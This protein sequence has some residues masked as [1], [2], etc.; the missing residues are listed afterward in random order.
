[1]SDDENG[2]ITIYRIAREAR[3]SPAP[4][5]RVLNGNQSVG[6][7]KRTRVEN[8]IAAHNYRPSAIARS[9]S[10]QE[11][12]VLG[13]I[14][15]DI[16]HP[17][18]HSLFLAAERKAIEMGYTILLGNTLNDNMTHITDME[19]HYIRLMLEKRVDA[20]LISG[21][22]IQDVEVSDEYKSEFRRTLRTTRIMTISHRLPWIECPSVMA[23]DAVGMQIAV[24]Y[25]VS[26]K[27]CR[28]GFLGGLR[29]IEPS[30]TR[31]GSFV[32]ALE[33]HGLE[34]REAWHLESGFDMEDGKVAMEALLQLRDKPT[35]IVCFN[36]LVA[37]GAIFA[38]H[39]AGLNLPEDLSI[40]SVDN[41]RH[42]KF[43]HPALTTVDVCASELGAL[44]VE[45]V[46]HALAGGL[47]EL[48][49][50]LTPRLVI[51]DSCAPPL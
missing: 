17:Y 20:I 13:F 21:G 1:M 29:G 48:H 42:S 31:L 43:V 9:L 50:V 3:V 36:D 25:L 16:S 5:S 12:R 19:Q 49:S 4:V 6:A 38:A 30:N 41:I 18:Y 47:E 2:R 23:D 46:V 35:A 45:R 8:V 7:E 27:H 22:R 10:G 51:R 37:I 32:K 34:Y 11:T 24:N 15:P 26:L 28:I 33:S 14:Q 44:A 39:R 40:T